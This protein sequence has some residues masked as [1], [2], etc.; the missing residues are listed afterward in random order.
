MRSYKLAMKSHETLFFIPSNTYG[1]SA[2]K[3]VLPDA[4]RRG[5]REVFQGGAFYQLLGPWAT[6]RSVR[7][8]RLAIRCGLPVGAKPWLVDWPTILIGISAIIWG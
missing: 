3:K 5:V 7:G 6:S 8:V 1:I 4:R 2:A